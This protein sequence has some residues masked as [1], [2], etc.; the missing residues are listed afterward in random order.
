MRI[1][2]LHS[3]IFIVVLISMASM[4][5]GTKTGS[6]IPSLHSGFIPGEQVD[7]VPYVWQEVNGFCLPSS[8]S[9]VLQSMGRNLSL[10]DIL[11]S[12]GTGFSIMSMSVDES[13]T[14]L[15]GVLIR[16]IPWLEFFTELQGVEMEIYLDSSTE[17][18]WSAKQILAYWE[19]NFTDY[20]NNAELTPIGVLRDSIDAGYPLAIN[21][22][23]FYLPPVDWDIIR[24]YIGP[25]KPGGVGHAIVIVGYNDTSQT[26]R[27]HDPGVGLIEPYTG[28]PVDGRWNYT[29]SYAMLDNAWRSGGYVTFRLANGTGPAANFEERLVAYISQ[30]LI[31]N[32]TSYFE[33]LENYFYLSTGADAFRGMGLDLTSNAIHD[34]CTYYLEVDKP[35]AIRMLG[36]N[37]ETMMTM[38]YM[39][40]RGSLDSL[41]E[42]LPSYNLQEFL[43][44]ASKALP[45]METLSSNES[46]T[47]GITIKSR[48]TILYNTFFGMADSFETSHNLNEA[49]SEF[50]EE[51][52][53]IA[54]Y[55]FVIADAW[56]AAGEILAALVPHES[57]LSANSNIVIVGGG[58]VL[59]IGI[60][61]VLWRRRE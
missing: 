54:G 31:G 28:F 51:L 7:G 52:E 4:P 57:A 15:P 30:R 11:A 43:E 14:F 48:N 24:N 42:L 29:M 19:S 40:F 49:I 22:D 6:E 3:T 59:V 13:M 21:V 56:T 33:G 55:L 32:R 8:L 12:S 47:S 20:A 45:F 23:T 26:V 27:V 5:I 37:L 18:G 16:Q 9:M 53:E 10:Y 38:Q 35:T 2:K 50:S 1:T 17:F 58:A 36:H 44:E 39:A 46:V 34:Y 61:V 41:P 60:V 25:L